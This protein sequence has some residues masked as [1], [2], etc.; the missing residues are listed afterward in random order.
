M[1]KRII[2]SPL[3]REP[4]DT[5]VTAAKAMNF[6]ETRQ[7]G[8]SVDATF[9]DDTRLVVYPIE[10]DRTL[11]PEEYVSGYDV[12]GREILLVDDFERA[13]FLTKAESMKLGERLSFDACE[14]GLCGK[15]IPADRFQTLLANTLKTG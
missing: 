6:L 3:N 11:K 9:P 7:Y 2:R 4:K 10:R 5:M 8:V 15:R 14:E 12:D 13:F 1:I